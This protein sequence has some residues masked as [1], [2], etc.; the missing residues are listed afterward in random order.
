MRRSVLGI[1]TILLIFGPAPAQENYILY[2]HYSFNGLAINPA[3]TGSHEMLNISMSHRSQWVGFEGAPSYNII[4]IHTPYK[5]T[6]MGLGILVMNESI[7]LRKFT[8]VYANYSH[9]MSVGRGKLALGLKGGISTGKIDDVDLGDDH[10]FNDQRRSFLLPNFGVGVYY[11][12]SR[13][14]AGISIPHLLGYKASDNGT[15]SAYHDF[16]RY[17]YYLTA[18]VR[19]EL[20]DKW[21]LEPSALVNYNN[22]G[23]MIAEGGLNLWYREAFRFGASYRTKQAIIALVDFK[24]NYQL[25]VGVA[26]DYGLNE[27][28]EYNRNSFEIAL[29]YNFGYRIRASN[30]SVF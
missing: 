25:R 23:G 3:Y 13:F 8:S 4:G 12:T 18:G 29:E 5:H 15:I 10:V 14:H 19:L 27:L 11:Y 20:S 28:N 17:C 9:R 1:L 6:R 26:Y 16:K 21:D 30:P 24:V 2:S 22:S 7:G